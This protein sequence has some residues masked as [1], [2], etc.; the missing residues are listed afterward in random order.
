MGESHGEGSSRRAEPR[1][2]DAVVVG[3]RTHQRPTGRRV[4]RQSDVHDRM[5]C[6]T[7]DR[8]RAAGIGVRL[9]AAVHA[10]IYCHTRPCVGRQVE[11]ISRRG[12]RDGSGRD[13]HVFLRGK[14]GWRLWQV[15]CRRAVG[16]GS[17][18]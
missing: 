16:G 13:N 12:A 17:P 14:G 7:R 1:S 9:R 8:E 10:G 5:L 18:G 4:S 15:S 3:G 2:G 11:T 6:S